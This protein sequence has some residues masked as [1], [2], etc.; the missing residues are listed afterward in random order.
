MREQA[1]A[2]R[3]YCSAQCGEPRVIG[4]RPCST[5][6]FGG[7]RRA[8]RS[9]LGLCR[10]RARR[11]KYAVVQVPGAAE[12]T[13][14]CRAGA[15][16]ETRKVQAGGAVTAHAGSAGSRRSYHKLSTLRCRAYARVPLYLYPITSAP[17]WHKVPSCR[18][19]LRRHTA[20]IT[21][22]F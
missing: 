19:R 8:T 13:Q 16:R 1:L 17:F 2:V 20:T 7:M 11:E 4:L 5:Q 14:L 15:R 12:N 3:R 10:R 6:S 22:S 18:G 21:H 9:G